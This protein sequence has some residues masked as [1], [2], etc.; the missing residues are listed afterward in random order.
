[1][2]AAWEEKR[3]LEVPARLEKLLGKCSH[4]ATCVRASINIQCSAWRTCWAALE[5][6]RSS[7]VQK[8]RWKPAAAHSHEPGGASTARG[9]GASPPSSA[10]AKHLLCSSGTKET[11]SNGVHQLRELVV[12]LQGGS[13]P[14]HQQGQQVPCRPL[15]CEQEETHKVD[16]RGI[17][18][19]AWRST[20]GLNVGSICAGWLLCLRGAQRGTDAFKQC[21]GDLQVARSQHPVQW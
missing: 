16:Q 14:R 18:C 8:P 15:Q 11:R 10:L 4:H 19:T 21:V 7:H 6:E 13:V 5:S 12:T 17:H 9:L 1:V 2:Q 3:P 20:C